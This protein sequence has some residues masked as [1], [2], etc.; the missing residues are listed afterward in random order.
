M[1]SIAIFTLKVIIITFV[2]FTGL[3][4][5]FPAKAF[6][7]ISESINQGILMLSHDSVKKH[8]IGSLSSQYAIDQKIIELQENKDFKMIEFAEKHKKS[9]CN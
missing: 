9:L 1:K 6:T 7:L 8:L 5:Y 3:Q 2:F 4:A